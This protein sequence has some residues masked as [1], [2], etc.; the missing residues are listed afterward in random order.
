MENTYQDK[1]SRKLSRICQLLQTIYK[2]LQLYSKTSQQIKR[3]KR[4]E[5]GRGTVEGI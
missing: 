5:M 4:V 3:Q 1:G 2:E